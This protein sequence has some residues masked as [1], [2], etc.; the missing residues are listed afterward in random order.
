M[1]ETSDDYDEG[2]R[3]GPQRQRKNY[4]NKISPAIPHTELGYLGSN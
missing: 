2:D 3:D 4:I 1:T